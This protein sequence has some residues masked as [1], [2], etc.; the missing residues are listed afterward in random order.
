MQ[1]IN[2][3]IKQSIPVIIHQVKRPKHT[4]T[5][6]K[7]GKY[8]KLNKNGNECWYNLSTEKWID[9]KTG[10]NKTI[11]KMVNWCS[12]CNVETKNYKFATLTF[13]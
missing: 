12:G 7:D 2:Q 5:M 1:T 9:K 8:I 13:Q 4:I 11:E 6:Q 10:E 3:A